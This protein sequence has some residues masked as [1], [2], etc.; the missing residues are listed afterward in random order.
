MK[1]TST[2][3]REYDVRG[4][5]GKEFS[6]KALKEYEKWY[7]KFPGVNIT[8]EVAEAI[9]KGY[10]TLIKKRGGKKI[11]IGHEF[12]P[13]GEEMKMLFADGVR[14]TGVDVDDAGLSLTPIVY[15]AT[16]FYD[17]DGGVNVTGSHNVYFF[18]GFK[19]MAKG[20]SPIFGEEIQTL[21]KI[22]EDES[23]DTADTPGKYEK[24]EVFPDYKKYLLDHNKLS[25]KLKVVLDCGNGSAGKF[26]PE[27]FGELGCDLVEMYTTPDSSFPNHLPDPEDEYLMKDLMAKVKEEKAD[28]GIALDA[29]GDRCGVVNEKG[30]FVYADRMLLLM[31][32]DV[33]SRNKNKK[34]LYDVKCT[35]LLEDLVPEF[36]GLPLMHV[37]GHA[38]IKNT[39]RK[40]LDV[41]LSGEVSGHF[42]FAE[43]YFRIDDGVYAAAKILSLLA[44]LSKP[45]SEI[46]KQFPETVMT[47][48]LKLPC[49]DSAKVKVVNAIRDHFSSKYETI[50]I[51][52]VRVVFSP[53]SWGLVRASNTSPYLTIRV[54]ADTEKEVLEIKNILADELEKYPEVTDKLNRKEVTSRTGRLGWV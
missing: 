41:I 24:R 1:V 9:G 12:R 16:A 49:E 2:I 40:D 3:F 11:I 36:G 35:H 15:F 14:S 34:I 44:S 32:K 30:E 47:P 8:P 5:A 10:G 29:D 25:K 27:I 13:W 7:G 43:D 33:L 28:I 52:G 53:T 17:Y 48:E 45:L 38:P 37:T 22:V 21:R 31:A 23:W 54:E 4:I 46:M 6:D 39:M 19:M 51:D 26:A 18:N 20:V 50:N 42:Y